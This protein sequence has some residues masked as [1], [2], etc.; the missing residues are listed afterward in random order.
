MKTNTC[1][2]SYL[3]FFRN[4]VTFKT[5]DNYGHNTMLAPD[6]GLHVKEVISNSVLW[7]FR[8]GLSDF[9][10]KNSFELFFKFHH[11]T[12]EYHRRLSQIRKR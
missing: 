5:Q 7:H 10:K 9:R 1:V 11:L 6:F 12:L 2:Q 8:V 3:L 4:I